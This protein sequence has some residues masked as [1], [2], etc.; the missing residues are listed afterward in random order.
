MDPRLQGKLEPSDVVQETLL[1]AHRARDQFRWQGDAET[2]AWLR[3]ILAN[4]L[5]DAVRRFGAEA[6]D[7]N[8]EY[9]LE[10]SLA[11]S[12]AR[13]EQ[14]LAAERSSPSEAAVRQEELF[15][16]AEAL[17]R[18]PQDQ[19]TA[20]ELMHCQGCSLKEIGERM[21]RSPT[22]VGGLLRRG[23]R[24]LRELLGAAGSDNH[25]P[26]PDAPGP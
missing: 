7:F 11:E 24:K 15:R 1:K 8:R 12:S 25:V 17:A 2:A 19:R 13:L 5:T 22:A 9:S 23:M 6:R 18:L 16:L 10:Q 26:R 3:R 4:T 20:L 21:G 14:W